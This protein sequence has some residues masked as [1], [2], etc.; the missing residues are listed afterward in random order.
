[1]VGI[2]SKEGNMTVKI[3]GKMLSAAKDAGVANSNTRKAPLKF[4]LVRPRL[5]RV[6]SSSIPSTIAFTSSCFT[7][8]EIPALLGCGASK[9][10]MA[11]SPPFTAARMAEVTSWAENEPLTLS[12]FTALVTAS[13]RVTWGVVDTAAVVAFVFMLCFIFSCCFC[14]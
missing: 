1:M 4:T 14:F 7:Q 5:A 9:P 11:I 2:T 10:G 12:S 3:S 13:L 6:P 8:K